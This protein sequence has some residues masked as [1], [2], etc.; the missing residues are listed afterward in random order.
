MVNQNV[1]QRGFCPGVWAPLA[2][3]DGLLVRVRARRGRLDAN[4]IR[5]LARAARTFGN[6]IIEL[7]RR[8]NLQ[9]RGV[10]FSSLPGLQTELLRLQLASPSAAV[11]RRPA[12]WVCL[13]DGLDPRC[14]PLE[15]VAEALDSL[16]S[17]PELTR[18]LSDK[19][20]VIVSG[21]SALSAELAGD[22]RVQ[23]LEARP[24]WAHLSIA[25]AGSSRELG[26]CRSSDVRRAVEGLLVLLGATVR[27]HKRMG[28][29]L[30]PDA[31]A[32][33]AAALTPLLEPL[34]CEASWTAELLGFQASPRNW[35][36]FELPFGSLE[37][38]GWEAVADLAERFGSGEVRLLPGRAL[39]LPD[40]REI[41]RQPL[42]Q[43]AAAAHFIVERPTPWLRLVACS[44]APACRSAHAET[45][46]L[47]SE[48]ASLVRARLRHDTTLHV[49]GCEK[50]CAWSGAADITLVHGSDGSRLGWGANVAQTARTAA[51]SLDAIRERLGLEQEG[52]PA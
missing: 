51:L 36:G 3:G 24:G 44:G 49:S 41:H 25:G 1:M 10:S 32:R 35:F 21:G 29:L 48:L 39:L 11:E 18:N 28:Q 17:T 40:V 7:T 6:G 16:L 45:R 2:S 13:L 12:L 33:L 19:F 42:A 15:P 31:S 14:P 9:L 30:V 37:A 38:P 34:P 26:A 43:R 46:Q 47:A 4:Q 20:S 50:G 5:G 52:L 27:E 23:L 22:V 8:A